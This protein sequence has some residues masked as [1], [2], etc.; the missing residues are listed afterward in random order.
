MH[1][2]N[3]AR[4]LQLISR[5]VQQLTLHN[6]YRTPLTPAIATPGSATD[7]LACAS[8]E[9]HAGLAHRSKHARLVCNQLVWTMVHLDMYMYERNNSNGS[10]L[11]GV[12]D[13]GSNGREALTSPDNSPNN[14]ICHVVIRKHA[15]DINKERTTKI[16]T[17]DV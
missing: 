12:R 8:L 3:Q 16:H 14:P 9:A 11:V 5:Q 17:A 4:C 10:C 15:P 7:Y 13:H 2:R 1:E 6:K